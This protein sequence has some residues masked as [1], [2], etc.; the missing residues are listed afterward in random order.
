MEDSKKS[1]KWV[2]VT[3]QFPF[4][5]RNFMPNDFPMPTQAPLQER[6]KPQPCSSNEVYLFLFQALNSTACRVAM[7]VM[8]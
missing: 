8:K 6:K 1:G 3:T 4:I 5:P 7:N 2:K